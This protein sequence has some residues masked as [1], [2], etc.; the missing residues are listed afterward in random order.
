MRSSQN[1]SANIE[2]TALTFVVERMSCGHCTLAITDEVSRLSEV[3]SVEV[4][5][6]AKLVRVRGTDVDAGDVVSAIDEAGYD[7]V[8]A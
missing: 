1:D 7:A 6:D 3:E 4:D 5:L 2:P 8:A